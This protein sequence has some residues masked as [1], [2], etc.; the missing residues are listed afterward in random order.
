MRARLSTPHF[1]LYTFIGGGIPHRAQSAAHCMFSHG[2]HLPR[3][4]SVYIHIFSIRAPCPRLCA[5]RVHH[6]I[7]RFCAMFFYK[8]IDYYAALPLRHKIPFCA[9]CRSIP[10]L[11]PFRAV[12]PLPRQGG[13]TPRGRR[14]RLTPINTLP[15][16]AR[17][18]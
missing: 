13:Y 3:P 15:R 2:A 18:D 12:A 4:R 10:T 1:L 8:N 7:G 9:L 16:K 11:S 14:G 6:K 17:P 5:P